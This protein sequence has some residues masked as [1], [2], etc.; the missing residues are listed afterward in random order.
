M[1][2]N[3][4]PRGRLASREIAE[5]GGAVRELQ[6]VPAS[7]GIALERPLVPCRRFVELRSIDEK[8]AGYCAQDAR[9]VW[10]EVPF[11]WR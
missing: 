11:D 7:L 4:A 8:R 5:Q 10:I 6:R 2:R 1:Q 3:R 9:I